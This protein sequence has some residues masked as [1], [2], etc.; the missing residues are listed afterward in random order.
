M[1]NATNYYTDVFKAWPVKMVGPKPTEAMLDTVHKLGLRPGKQA[2]AN[3]MA[4]RDCGVTGSQIVIVC[5]APQ[6]NRMRDLITDALVKREAMP[7]VN[8]NTVYKLAVTPKGL[9]RIARTEKQLA[10]AAEAGK[11]DGA[12]KAKAVKGTR[13]PKVAAETVTEQP[14][15]VTDAPVEQPQA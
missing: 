6:L 2:L 14:A 1:S 13:K 7:K 10:Q 4:L 15:P 11:A 12:P 8:G 9:Q 3:A 5:S